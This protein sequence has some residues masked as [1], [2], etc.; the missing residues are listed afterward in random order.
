MASAVSEHSLTLSESAE[1][2]SDEAELDQPARE[3]S[4]GT[5]RDASE[6]PQS[7]APASKAAHPRAPALLPENK[8]KGTLTGRAGTVQ[9]KA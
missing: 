8:R 9:R 5:G 3:S 1:R 4:L 2:V 6:E 7:R